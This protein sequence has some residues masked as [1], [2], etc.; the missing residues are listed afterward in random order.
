MGSAL[1]LEPIKKQS[2]AQ[3]DKRRKGTVVETCLI[4]SI[5]TFYIL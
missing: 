3:Q 2:Q 4:L 1:E 5:W